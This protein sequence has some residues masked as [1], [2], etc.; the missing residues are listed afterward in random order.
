M[1]VLPISQI[2]SLPACMYQ[3]GRILPLEYIFRVPPPET[4]EDNDQ[5]ATKK[6]WRE[7][8]EAVA[9]ERQAV[10]TAGSIM[11][12]RALDRGYRESSSYSLHDASLKE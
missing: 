1:P 5:Y 10:W 11:E 9:V 6:T 2:P 4:S 8:R 12:G 7:P 3:A